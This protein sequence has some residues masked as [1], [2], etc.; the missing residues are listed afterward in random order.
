MAVEL[1]VLA[2]RIRLR[3]GE[4][5]VA[6]EQLDAAATVAV[7]PADR[8]LVAEAFLD[9]ATAHGMDRAALPAVERALKQAYELSPARAALALAQF[10]QRQ[11][12]L[13]EAAAV[14]RAAIHFDPKESRYYLSLARVYEQIAQPQE[15][16]ATYLAL[17]DAAPTGSNY[18]IV[19]ERLDAL[20]A[21]L[22][23]G[24]LAQSLRL[25]VIGNATLDYLQS[26]IK[27]ECYRAGIRPTVHQGGFDQY[28]QEI[29]NQESALYGFDPEVVI[30]AIHASRV[31]PQIHQYP[32][33][34][35]VEDRHA[36][37]D[38]GLSQ[39]EALLDVFTQHSTALVLLHN[40]VAP[41]FPALGILDLR[42][43]FGQQAAVAE[44]NL[45]LAEM[46]RTRYKSV[47]IVDEDRIQ[48]RAGKAD[49][50]DQRLWLSASIPWGERV[51]A[52]LA[53][54][55]L[56]FVKPYKGLIRKCIVLDLDN[57][58]WGGVIGE[59]GLEG[60]QIGTTA[61][62]NAF[63]AFQRELERLW[64]RGILLA[65]CSKNNPEDALSVFAQH[66]DMVL[67]LSHFAAQRI[68]WQS[69]PQNVREIAQELNIGLDSL[70]FL[71]DNPVERARMR[72]EL[73]QVLTPEL[74]TD[75]AY[76]RPALLD[77]GVFD[78]L[79]L[80]EEDLHRNRFYVEEKAR[81]EFQSSFE[82]T[83]SV[84]DYLASLEIRIEI[85]AANAVSMPRIA[86]LTSKTNQF[87]LTTR[88]YSEA[89][90]D[91]L[92]AKG[93]VVYTA[94]VK[95]RFGDNGLT[96]VIIATPKDAETWEIDN[97]L[98]SCRVLDRGVEASLVTQAGRLALSRGAT[99]LQG[100]FLPTTKNAPAR[101]CYQ[102]L[103]FTLIERDAGG[104]ELWQLDVTSSLPSVAPWLTVD[105]P[106]PTGVAS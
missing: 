51:L 30:C 34:L 7:D 56:R 54:E 26:Y 87:N 61:P 96:G 83:G 81:Q 85:A 43:E 2:A 70:V 103:G 64:Q 94:R 33:D 1:I 82:A 25:A 88:R 15:A 49:A 59:D 98:M 91:D 21:L 48:A 10:L 55:Y 67:K 12:R 66:P 100:R 57:T 28:A 39:L 76:Y 93:G 65:V 52:G 14:W 50:T 86:Q 105:A 97:L 72:A 36:E 35:S 46:A 9:L 5:R 4:H 40:M 47:F 62:G 69:K 6:E 16:F 32:F 22:P 106:L 101:D 71:D 77:L 29:L 42:D 74:P 3:R 99:A 13:E 19:S 95:D 41:Q 31:F 37:I 89:Q 84:E 44:I 75:P 8:S 20:A 90:L 53:R 79:A 38:V 92:Q 102:R 11:K 24:S 73:P 60:I 27:V 63:R 17:L 78:A 23:E 80:T 68:N 45:R 104:N 18:L 58:L